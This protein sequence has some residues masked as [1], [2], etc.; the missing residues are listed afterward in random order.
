MAYFQF[1]SGAVWVSC[2]DSDNI[3]IF[4]L[5]TCNDTISYILAELPLL[6]TLITKFA[7]QQMENFNVNHNYKSRKYTDN[8]SS[9]GCISSQNRFKFYY[10]KV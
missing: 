2:Y 5:C 1:L 9:S 4:Y 8:S 7:G 10:F 3:F 6:L